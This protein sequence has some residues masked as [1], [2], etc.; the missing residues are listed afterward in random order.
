MVES[1]K[2]RVFVGPAIGIIYG[3][4]HD[5][6]PWF[7]KEFALEIGMQ[8]VIDDSL[9]VYSEFR[10]RG[11]RALIGGDYGF[12]QSPQGTNARDLKHFVDLLGY[13]PSEALICGTKH[14]GQ[15]MEMGDELG[16]VKEGFLADLL[17]VGADPLKHIEKMVDEDNLHVIMKDGELYKD[18]SKAALQQ[19]K[20]A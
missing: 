10:K 12:I 4:I 14:G 3:T 2:D 19:E 9:K 17:L 15:V 8:R 18:I 11:V 20:A 16:Q 6:E 7:S 5:G 13:S 1:V